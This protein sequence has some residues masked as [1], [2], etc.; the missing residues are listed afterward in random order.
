[1]QEDLSRLNLVELLERL[2]PVPEPAAVPLWPQTVAWLWIG[3]LLLSVVLWLGRRWQR[4]RHANAYRRAA[5]G[6]IAA[7]GDDPAALAAILRRT[8]LVAF[9]R[10]EVAG[11]YGDAWLAFLD[12]AY[13]GAEFTR[14]P[15]RVLAT[16]PWAPGTDAAGLAPLV[17]TWVRRHRRPEEQRS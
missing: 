13:G 2:E 9:P 10:R 7:A 12:R 15:G 16:A 11:L 1:M 8:A 5:L 17:A 14:G 6:A 4:H 3:L